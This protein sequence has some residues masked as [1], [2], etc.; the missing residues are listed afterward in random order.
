M[1]F[2]LKCSICT[3]KSVKQCANSKNEME[4]EKC[5]STCGSAKN[6]KCDGNYASCLAI[7]RSNLT[8]HYWQFVIH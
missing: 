4:E 3:K 1:P 2:S 7:P 6:K 8:E 5:Y